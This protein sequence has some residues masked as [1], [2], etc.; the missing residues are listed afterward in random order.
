MSALPATSPDH[1]LTG[2]SAMAIPSPD[3][4]FVDWHFVDAFLDTSSLL[5]SH[6]VHEC[7][8][9]LRRHGV[10]L[11]LDRNFYAANRDR[12]LLDL[13]ISNL[14][15]TRRPDHLRL[16]DY[17]DNEADAL[18]LR[19]QLQSLCDRL[20]DPAQRRLLEEWLAQQ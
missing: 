3:T 12:A 6:G 8:G 19:V 10:P 9:T 5:G 2:T 13:I 20:D 17:C 15:Q 16:E 18:P 11:P 4:P 1:Y 7:S 14:L